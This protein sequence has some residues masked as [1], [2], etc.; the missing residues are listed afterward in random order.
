MPTALTTSGFLIL[1][2]FFLQLLNIVCSLL[3]LRDQVHALGQQ[4]IMGYWRA[5]RNWMDVS[6]FQ[7]HAQSAFMTFWVLC[8]H[9]YRLETPA[10]GSG[11][12]PSCYYD[13]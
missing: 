2:P 13:L 6:L 3:Q 5:P 7:R 8:T 1:F 9:Y 11:S 4:G 10:A 12:T